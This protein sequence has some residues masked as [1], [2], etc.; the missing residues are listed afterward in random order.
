MFFLVD[1][2]PC[3]FM[4]SCAASYLVVW[5]VGSRLLSGLGFYPFSFL[6]G[7]RRPS[8]RV[9]PLSGLDFCKFFLFR[10]FSNFS[11]VFAMLYIAFTLGRLFFGVLSTPITWPYGNWRVHQ[12]LFFSCN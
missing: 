9:P 7:Y 3:L 11:V 6:S 5:P 12:L 1:S 8:F 2:G 10:T 4:V